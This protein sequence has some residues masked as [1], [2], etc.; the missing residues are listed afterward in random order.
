[1]SNRKHKVVTIA[2]TAAGFDMKVY[3]DRR[4]GTALPTNWKQQA[5]VL[6]TIGK[7]RPKEQPKAKGAERA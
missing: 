7:M 2:T 6:A 3:V 4:D 5:S 1:M